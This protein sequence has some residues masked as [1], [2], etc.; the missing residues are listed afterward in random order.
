M[1]II[2]LIPDL[3]EQIDNIDDQSASAVTKL[4]RCF[5]LILIRMSL[6]YKM[7]N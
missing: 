3:Q 7:G 4:G 2:P 5:Y 1:A 6:L